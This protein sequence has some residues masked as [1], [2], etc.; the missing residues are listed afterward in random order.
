MRLDCANENTAPEERPWKI[1]VTRFAR[2]F[3]MSDSNVI[4][5][6]KRPAPK[7][8]VSE[9]ELDAIRRMTRSWHP[10]LQKLMFPE[11][12]GEPTPTPKTRRE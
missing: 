3:Q 12:F 6:R 8:Q 11:H 5:F 1:A 10:E 7:K 9:L 4:P 2:A